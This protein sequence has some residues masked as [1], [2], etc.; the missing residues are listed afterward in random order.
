M[1]SRV[2]NSLYGP[3]VQRM[4]NGSIPAL[5][6]LPESHF[7]TIQF[8]RRMPKCCA[9]P[10]LPPRCGASSRN[11]TLSGAPQSLQ[12][13]SRKLSVFVT[14]GLACL[15]AR[16]GASVLPESLTLLRLSSKG[17]SSFGSRRR[18][19]SPLLSLDPDSNLMLSTGSFSNACTTYRSTTIRNEASACP[20]CSGASRAPQCPTAGKTWH[21]NLDPAFANVATASG[22][23]K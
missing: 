4:T 20:T 8:D 12:L 7:I 3:L 6:D 11:R 19:P 23:T 9:S 21:S 1:V 17:F 14:Y 13:Q 2:P 22:S 15:F 16:N 5:S 18:R 10:A